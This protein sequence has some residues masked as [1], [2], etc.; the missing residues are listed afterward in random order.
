MEKKTFEDAI[1]EVI[2]LD[3]VDVIVTSN[4]DPDENETNKH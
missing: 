3:G 1:L 4:F 2:S